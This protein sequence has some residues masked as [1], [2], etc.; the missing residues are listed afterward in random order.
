MEIR[1][2]V[3]EGG[4]METFGNGEQRCTTPW[5]ALPL[6]EALSAV[7][8]G[9]GMVGKGKCLWNAW[10]W[11]W[12]LA[13][14]AYAAPKTVLQTM[15]C[16]AKSE[17]GHV[18]SGIAAAHSPRMHHHSERFPSC[19]GERSKLKKKNTVSGVGNRRSQT[20]DYQKE[21]TKHPGSTYRGW[22]SR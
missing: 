2:E 18:I 22:H 3:V 19:N 16:N 20:L 4:T 15:E 7:E 6:G 1:N 9:G 21:R 11:E 14:E 8:T 10:K 5:L 12:W 17:A 13:P